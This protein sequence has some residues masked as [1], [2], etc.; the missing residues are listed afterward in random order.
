MKKAG[1]STVSKSSGAQKNLFSFFKKST[2]L[3][4]EMTPEES[5]TVEVESSILI[6]SRA[7]RYNKYFIFRYTLMYIS[8]FSAFYAVLKF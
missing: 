6:Y 5:N 1:A 2:A 4:V 8:I 7:L 3:P